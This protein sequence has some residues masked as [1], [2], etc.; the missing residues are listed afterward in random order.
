MNPAVRMMSYEIAA[1]NFWKNSISC[2]QA[3]VV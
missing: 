1:G 2:P 3:P